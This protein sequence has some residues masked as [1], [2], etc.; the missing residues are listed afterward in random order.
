V[1]YIPEEDAYYIYYSGTTGGT[2]D[3]IGLAICAAGDDGY[4]SVTPKN[5][6]RHGISPV[7]APEPNAPF[8]ENVVHQ[9]AVM[10][11]QDPKTKKWSWYMYYSYRG[12]NGL[13]PGIRLATSEDGKSW[14]R[15]LNPNDPRK[16]GQIFESTP[17]AFYEWHQIFKVDDTY[18][19]SMEV[20]IKHGKRWRPGIAV[21][22]DPITGWRQLDVDTGLQTEWADVYDERLHFHVATPAFYKI[23][24]KWYLYAQACGYPPSGN[25]NDGS[26][27]LWCFECPRKVPTLPGYADLFLPGT[28]AASSGPK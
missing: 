10:R 23:G 9:S 1:L 27:D 25:Y 26:W 24:D 21:S 19:L 2:Q 22:K 17:E 15:R 28:P 20:G 6:V 16:M 18:F 13:L 12:K 11:E 7:L 4:S 3:N 8:Y 14:T 5:I